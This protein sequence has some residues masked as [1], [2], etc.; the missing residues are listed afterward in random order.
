M[1][2]G[3]ISKYISMEKCTFRELLFYSYS[4]KGKLL[5]NLVAK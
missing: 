1:R 2:D 3:E 5:F 4:V